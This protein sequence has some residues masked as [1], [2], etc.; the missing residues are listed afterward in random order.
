MQ[1]PED[2]QPLRSMASTVPVVPVGQAAATA[3]PAVAAD[4][5]DLGNGVRRLPPVD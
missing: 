5:L 2:G 4:P 3:E 1:A